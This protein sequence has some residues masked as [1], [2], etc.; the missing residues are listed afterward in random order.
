MRLRLALWVI[1]AASLAFALAGLGGAFERGPFPTPT[2][3]PCPPV[4][5]G[6]PAGRPFPTCCPPGKPLPP[7]VVPDR[8]CPPYILAPTGG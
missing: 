4:P 6:A 2:R 5:L 8:P 7:Q 3:T 1:L